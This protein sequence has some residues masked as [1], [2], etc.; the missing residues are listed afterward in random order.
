VRQ[1]SEDIVKVTVDVPR[2]RSSPQRQPA[3]PRPDSNKDAELQHEE[4][5]VGSFGSNAAAA[6]CSSISGV[7][8][9]SFVC[10]FRD[11]AP[12]T[13]GVRPI[14]GPGEALVVQGTTIKP[15]PTLR[16]LQNRPFARLASPSRSPSPE[17]ASPSPAGRGE[18]KAKDAAPR[19]LP[20]HIVT[21]SSSKAESGSVPCA[22]PAQPEALEHADSTTTT[23][24]TGCEGV[25]HA[26]TTREPATS[27]V[28]PVLRRLRSQ[29]Q[30]GNDAE[31]LQRR[32]QAARLLSAPET[33]F[34]NAVRTAVATTPPPQSS[35]GS[36]GS[37]APRNRAR[38]LLVPKPAVGLRVQQRPSSQPT[39][40]EPAATPRSLTV[41][42]APP[43]VA[44]PV[45]LVNITSLPPPEPPAALRGPAR[46]TTLRPPGPQSL[47]IHGSHAHRPPLPLVA[48]RQSRSL[49]SARGGGWHRDI[50]WAKLQRA[51]SSEAQ[52]AQREPARLLDAVLLGRILQQVET[53]A[54]CG[55]A[56]P[57]P[58]APKAAAGGARQDV[59]SLQVGPPGHGTAREAE[60]EQA[61]AAAQVGTVQL[62]GNGVPA[63]QGLVGRTAEPLGTKLLTPPLPSYR[64]VERVDI[65]AEH[66]A[67]EQGVQVSPQQG[68]QVSPQQGVQVSPQ[69][70]V[71]VSPQPGVQ[72]SETP[73]SFAHASIAGEG[74]PELTEASASSREGPS[75][76][77]QAMQQRQRVYQGALV[78]QRSMPREGKQ[79]SFG[80]PP[81]GEAG[82][83]KREISRVHRQITSGALPGTGFRHF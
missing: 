15:P 40:I 51:G 13:A 71:Q 46:A 26:M 65:V 77:A 29:I 43:R 14:L 33:A 56:S 41:P 27:G 54:D 74:V 37:I 32:R 5:L 34:Q 8:T 61:P 73:V 79:S 67:A 35:T 3:Q 81:C 25:A 48:E 9:G 18:E 55:L 42:P 30:P 63:P 4:Y 36:L 17:R 53:L 75:P 80:R 11:C 20:P 28:Q 76:F 64:L 52:A 50:L 66:A 83:L 72:V 59:E 16:C 69:Q 7:D 12:P 60:R 19:P 39:A 44:A 38:P 45:R 6:F 23:T 31:L 68:V 1:V 78:S 49:R 10:I 70:G 62:N 82:A 22:L 21:V 24:A 58:A 2:H 57:K 47:L